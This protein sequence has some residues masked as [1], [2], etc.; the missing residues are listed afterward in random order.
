MSSKNDSVWPSYESGIYIE[1]KLTEIDYPYEHKH[2]AYENMSHA[3]LTHLPIIYKLAFKS[4]REK[5]K[6][7]TIDRNNMKMELLNWVNDVWNLY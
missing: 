6:A 1:D 4:E 5:G 2:V 3:L 7:C